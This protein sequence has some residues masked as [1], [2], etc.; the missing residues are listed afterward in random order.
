MRTRNGAQRSSIVDPFDEP[1]LR[2]QVP[3]DTIERGFVLT[4]LAVFRWRVPAQRAH[5]DVPFIPGPHPFRPPSAF[6]SPRT[7]KRKDLPALAF[8]TEKCRFPFPK[9]HARRKRRPVDAHGRRRLFFPSRWLF[10]YF[11]QNKPVLLERIRTVRVE[12]HGHSY[13]AFP[14]RALYS[15]EGDFKT[16]RI[17]RERQ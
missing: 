7:G 4:R 15:R 11:R 10:L 3:V 12:Q 5:L 2:P 14:Y 9:L 1:A 6:S 8:T 17:G 13:P 16:S